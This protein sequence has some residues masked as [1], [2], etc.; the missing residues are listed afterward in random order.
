MCDLLQKLFANF[1][2]VE[3]QE[4]LAPACGALFRL[5]FLTIFR[6]VF[7]ML[8]LSLG[9]PAQNLFAEFRFIEI[10]AVVMV[11]EMV[12]DF[13]MTFTGGLVKV[14]WENN[15]FVFKVSTPK[16]KLAMVLLKIQVSNPGP[17]CCCMHVIS[18]WIIL[19]YFA[20]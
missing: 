14:A 10:I 7:F 13:E 9:D 6:H 3:K 2:S 19:K 16:K 17:S 1:L 15:D 5:M 4:L 18:I 11:V 20:W 12:T 8:K